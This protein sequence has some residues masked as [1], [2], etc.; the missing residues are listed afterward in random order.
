MSVII[1][2]SNKPVD[3]LKP[4]DGMRFIEVLERQFGE[5][6]ALSAIRKLR[7]QPDTIFSGMAEFKQRLERAI[8]GE[9]KLNGMDQ[10]YLWDVVQRAALR[11]F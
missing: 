11:L 5:N 4:V 9:Q 10:K 1:D 8:M 3:Q 6:V 2:I 7:E